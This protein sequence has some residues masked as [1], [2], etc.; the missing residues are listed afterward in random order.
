MTSATEVVQGLPVRLLAARLLRE[1][2]EYRKQLEEA[3]DAER[4]VLQL[5]PRDRAFLHALLVAALRHK[6]EINAVLRSFLEKPLPRK[7]GLT[8]FILAAGAAQL[9]FLDSP[10]HAV[11]DLAV[12][13]AKADSQAAHFTG[14]I[15]AVLRKVASDGAGLLDQ[16]D[17]ARVNTPDWLW[18]RWVANYGEDGA[19]RIGMAHLSQPPADLTVKSRPEDWAE[20]LQGTLLPTGSIRLSGQHAPFKDLPGYAEGA[21]WVQ[22]AAAALPVLL[23][24]DLA[25][26]SALDLCA[27]PGGKT[28]QLSAKGAAVTAVDVSRKRLVRLDENLARTGLV[29]RIIVSSVQKL[30][31]DERFDAVLLD[32]P[33]SATGTIRRH[34]ELPYLRTESQIGELAGVQRALLTAAAIHVAPGGLLVYSSCSLEP[35]EGEDQARDFLER[36]PPFVTEMPRIPALPEASVSAEGWLRILPFMQLGPVAGLDGFFIAAFRRNA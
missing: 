3:M 5:D 12:R 13:S 30:E 1:V 28:L 27:A 20:K 14:L 7:S 16:I 18:Q 25:G 2:L 33:C 9:L 6:G 17:A 19:R 8:W 21:W 11:I 31:L 24:G 36:H 4:A 15:N 22:D 26:K 10:A 32:A 34:P 29:A 35:E 23:F